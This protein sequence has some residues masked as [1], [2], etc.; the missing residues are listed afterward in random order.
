MSIDRDESQTRRQWMIDEFQQA[1]RRRL[2]SAEGK[3]VESRV[4]ADRNG[5]PASVHVD[6]MYV[7]APSRPL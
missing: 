4:E 7:D 6:G 1:R 2:V 5:I 3:T